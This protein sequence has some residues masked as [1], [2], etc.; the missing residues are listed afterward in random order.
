MRLQTSK[1]YPFKPSPKSGQYVWEI[2]SDYAREE[3]K[4]THT[5]RSS[6]KTNILLNHEQSRANPS[7]SR[8]G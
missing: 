8:V 1:V 2:F 7:Q 4:V 6:H 5:T 3:C